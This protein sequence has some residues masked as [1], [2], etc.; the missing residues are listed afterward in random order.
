MSARKPLRFPAD[1]LEWVLCPE[2]WF[3]YVARPGRVCPM[4]PKAGTP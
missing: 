3:R 4:C 2:C 1:V